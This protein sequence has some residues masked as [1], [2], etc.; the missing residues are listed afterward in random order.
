MDKTFHVTDYE[1]SFSIIEK[2]RAGPAIFLL[3]VNFFV[4]TSIVPSPTMIDEIG[5]RSRKRL[6]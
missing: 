2:L 3:M 5:G 6:K 1:L 4:E